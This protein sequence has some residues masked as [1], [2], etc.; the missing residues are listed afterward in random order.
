[1]S[2][3]IFVAVRQERA[4][5][6]IREVASELIA[7]RVKDPRI[8][9]VSIVKVEVTKDISLA[10]IYVSV[11][12]T[13]EEQTKTMEG[14]KSAQGLIRS[15]VAKALGIR[16]APSLQFI[17]DHGIEHSIHVSKLLK[18]AQKHESGESE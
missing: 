13:S 4:S 18:E 1:M 11:M 9:F 8:G 3:V 14:L 2:G 12:G 16:H 15:E 17:L 7:R 5:A 10:K 6:L